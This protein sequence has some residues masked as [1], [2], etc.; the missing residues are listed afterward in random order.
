MTDTEQYNLIKL[1]WY[2]NHTI[3]G[4]SP[5]NSTTTTRTGMVMEAI[6]NK[7]T[8]RVLEPGERLPSIRRFAATLG[9]SPS[10]VVEAYDR[11]AA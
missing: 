5:V 1:Y 11:L 3:K 2:K 10:T 8:S 6:R 4:A 9:V 7:I